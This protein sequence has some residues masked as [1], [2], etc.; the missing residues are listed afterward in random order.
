MRRPETHAPGHHE[1]GAFPPIA[2]CRTQL[3]QLLEGFGS[4]ESLRR[5]AFAA[6]AS[7]M[8]LLR[9]DSLR[10]TELLAWGTSRA[11]RAT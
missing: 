7:G 3:L 11:K 1:V 6:S 10:M 8:K 9:R 5:S 4:Q 2:R